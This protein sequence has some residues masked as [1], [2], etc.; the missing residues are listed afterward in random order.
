MSSID[1][2]LHGIARANERILDEPLDRRREHIRER[3]VSVIVPDL[4]TAFDMRLT[5]DG[6]TDVTH[7]ALSTPV[8][9]SQVTVTVSSDDLVAL[10]EDR[11][12]PAVALFSRRVKVD[13]TLGDLLHM[14]RLL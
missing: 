8:P 9:T 4:D 14:R 6:L 12:N 3:T 5:V 7:R 13:A 2:C 10:A 1:A 11:L